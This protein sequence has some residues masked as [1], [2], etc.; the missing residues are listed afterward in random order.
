MLGK[1]IMFN[2][3]QE[4][5]RD[6]RNAKAAMRP[7]FSDVFPRTAFTSYI[8]HV[9]AI[10]CG[11]RSRLHFR[12]NMY[13]FE[14]LA[15]RSSRLSFRNLHPDGRGNLISMHKTLRTIERILFRKRFPRSIGRG[16]RQCNSFPRA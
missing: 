13:Y 2:I 9:Y 14:T 3:R 11:I 10:D 12:Y 8:I 16:R 15:S 1:L 5:S 4:S 7:M 6:R